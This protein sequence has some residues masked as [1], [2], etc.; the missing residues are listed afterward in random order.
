MDPHKVYIDHTGNP[1]GTCASG[2]ASSVVL[3]GTLPSEGGEGDRQLQGDRTG[4][5]NYLAV[6]R[7]RR[8]FCF[9]NGE[10]KLV[11]LFFGVSLETIKRLA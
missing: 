3:P 5:Q 4:N 8:R 7:H 10:G 9:H 1:A 2:S 11:I 6:P